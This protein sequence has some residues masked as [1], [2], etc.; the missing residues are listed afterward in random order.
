MNR[1]PWRSRRPTGLTQ[2]R[3]LDTHQRRSR[4]RQTLSGEQ[5]ES[6]QLLAGDLSNA[7]LPLLQADDLQYVGAF[8]VPVGTFGSSTFSYGG[9]GLA[10]NPE[11][12]SLFAV[13][14]TRH[15][16]VAEIAIPEIVNS[17]QISH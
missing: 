3:L 13:G 11:H 2:S 1:S 16:E 14:H 15:Q 10:F 17:S 8:R 4:H 5:L 6:R 9:A 7:S 12:N